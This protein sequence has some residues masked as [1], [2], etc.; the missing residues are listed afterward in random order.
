M[1]SCVFTLL[2]TA[3]VAVALVHG[4]SGSCTSGSDYYTLL[5]STMLFLRLRVVVGGTTPTST[6]TM[7]QQLHRSEKP[8]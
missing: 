4:Q 3:A 2:L 7:R 6:M 8:S 5:T 1:Y